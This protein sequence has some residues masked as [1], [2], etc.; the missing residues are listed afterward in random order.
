MSTRSIIARV[1]DHEGTFV[2]RYI[3]WNGYPTWQG[4]QLLTLLKTKFKGNLHKMLV[5][6]ID[7]HPVG[8]S[9]LGEDC[10][11]HPQRSKR[12]EFKHRRAEAQTQIITEKNLLN[13]DAE[14]VYAFDEEKKRLYI[15]DVCAKEDVGLIELTGRM[16]AKKVWNGIECGEHFERCGHMAWAHKLLPRTSNLS[17]KTYLGLRPLDFHDVIAFVIDGVRYT[18][19][20]SGGNSDYL[21]RSSGKRYPRGTWVSSVKIG[22]ERLDLPVAKIIGSDYAPLPGVVWIMPPT[23]VNPKETRVSA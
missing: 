4:P 9:V 14:W 16:P 3:H 12:A 2:G 22:S 7:K 11:C 6:L 1:G 15:H 23:K 19:T 5:E 17:T 10:Y 20:G 13:S 18:A 21:A 8:W